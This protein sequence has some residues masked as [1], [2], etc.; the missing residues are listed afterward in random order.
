M[1]INLSELYISYKN[2]NYKLLFLNDINKDEIN[3]NNL[4]LLNIWTHVT[5]KQKEEKEISIK[6]NIK[7]D[8]T[9]F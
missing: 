3:L 7:N 6:L 1:I 5:Y 9:N 2:T 8:K 4:Q